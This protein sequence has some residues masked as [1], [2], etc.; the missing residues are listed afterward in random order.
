M[1]QLLPFLHFPRMVNLKKFFDKFFKKFLSAAKPS[2]SI[3][4]FWTPAVSFGYR[5][6]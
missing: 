4:Q 2:R 3:S 1:S 5:V 6:N